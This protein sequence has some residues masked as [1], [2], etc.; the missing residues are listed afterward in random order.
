[1]SKKIDVK[2]PVLEQGVHYLVSPFG[3]REYPKGVF[4]QHNGDDLVGKGKSSDWIV[5]IDEGVV[6]EVAYSSSR[7]YYIG[8]KM[9]NG[10]IT[11]YLHTKKGTTQVKKGQI[12]K[13]GQR[14]AYMGNSG[15][16]K[17]AKGKKHQVGT[18]LHFAVVNN[19]GN[20][21]DPMPYLM[22]EKDFN[23]G[24]TQGTYQV[25]FDKYLRTS[26]EVKT[27]NLVVWKSL[28]DS[29]KVITVA[30][31]V[32]KAKFRTYII[33]DKKKIPVTVE[34]VDFAI[35]KKGNVWGRCK[36]NETPIW[37]CVQ[38]KKGKQVKKV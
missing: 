9:K 31:K 33:K 19:G 2:C 4:T 24:W 30:D 36:T 20:F 12:V 25:L 10:Y 13:K 17:D 32:G 22:G 1:M 15:F 8:I 18:H 26:P 6:V 28:I 37:L 21:V 23:G 3:K 14:I 29:W 11:R 34:L 5:S 16:Y 38:D 7:G 35:D 27:T